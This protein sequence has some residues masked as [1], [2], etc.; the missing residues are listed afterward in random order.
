[1]QSLYS[2][3]LLP[4]F[5]LGLLSFDVRGQAV[6]R[7]SS[8]ASNISGQAVESF[9]AAGDLLFRRDGVMNASSAILTSAAGSFAAS[10]VGKTI[11]VNGAGTAGVPLVTRIIS[12][13]SVRQVT[14]AAPTLAA[15][16][17]SIY[18]YGTDDTAAF[19]RAINDT[20]AENGGVIVLGKK[21]YLISRALVLPGRDISRQQVALVEFRGALGPIRSNWNNV[22]QKLGGGSDVKLPIEGQT[23]LQTASLSGKMID[24]DWQTPV[25]QAP[26]GVQV[27]FQN[28]VFRVPAKSS[29]TGLDLQHVYSCRIIDV[30]VE[31]SDNQSN[32]PAPVPGGI[33]IRLPR[34]GNG[35][36][37]VLDRVGVAGFDTG[38]RFS[39][40]TE[41]RDVWI[42]RCRYALMAEAG[43]HA[44]QWGRVTI[45]WCPYGLIS[46]VN[47][48]ASPAFVTDGGLF[49]I[50]DAPVGHWAQTVAHIHDPGN[51]LHGSI[52]YHRVVPFVGK[53]SGIEV[54]G[55]RNLL[56]REYGSRDFDTG[57]ALVSLPFSDTFNRASFPGISN[58]LKW[59]LI[60][61]TTATIKNGSALLLSGNAEAIAW[62]ETD[63]NEY[64]VRAD[65]TLSPARAAAGL[66]IKYASVG[67]YMGVILEIQS[68]HN[69]VR[70]FKRDNGAYTDIA[71]APVPG[72]ALGRR[73]KLAVR[74]DTSTVKVFVDGAERISYTLTPPEVQRF[75]PLTQFG[76]YSYMSSAAEDGGSRWNDFSVVA[77]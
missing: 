37:V 35:A 13:R 33:G 56:R 17:D 51:N 55:A 53:Q 68:G 5:L 49:D 21:N 69:R 27:S 8:P 50:E 43:N 74:Y 29:T 32:L 22:D 76:L 23:I 34:V 64:E 36:Q 19:Q 4:F 15:V 48:P 44:S 65:V 61:G 42:Y 41:L 12:R 26:S 54:N 52:V 66:C 57:G 11:V 60:P 9:G 70:L 6:Q 45:H 14:L 72:M 58:D 3:F 30:T 25:G 31:P 47:V 62:L 7:T 16:S 28:I 63:V 40:H 46:E 39:E 1:M 24:V 71:T 67:T 75:G 18:Y 20:I 73:Y 2:L 38:I 10:D 59:K 77:Y